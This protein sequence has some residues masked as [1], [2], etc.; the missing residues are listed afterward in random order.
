MRRNDLRT[1]ITMLAISV[2]S[3]GC[4]PA[5]ERAGAIGPDSPSVRVFT[6][7]RAVVASDTN[8]ATEGKVNLGR[9]L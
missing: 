2:L 7:L 1:L 8:P 4:S 9:A 6:P 3:V 5:P